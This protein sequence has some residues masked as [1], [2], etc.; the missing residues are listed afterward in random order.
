MRE[1]DY[2]AILQV[3]QMSAMRARPQHHD[4]EPKGRYEPKVADAAGRTNVG[5]GIA[6]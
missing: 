6:E 1:F 5:F 3:Q 2:P 4:H